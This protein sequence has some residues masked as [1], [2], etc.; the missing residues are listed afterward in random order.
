MSTSRKLSF[1]L[2]ATLLAVAYT[3]GAVADPNKPAQTR[4]G[5][6]ANAQLVQV[7]PTSL[8]APREPLVVR[9]ALALCGQCPPMIV[10]GIGF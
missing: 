10:L 2:A 8:G 7:P 1:A 9:N 5:L 4:R 3:G 6:Q